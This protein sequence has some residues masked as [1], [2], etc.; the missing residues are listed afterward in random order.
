MTS[1]PNCGKPIDKPDNF[2]PN[3]GHKLSPQTGSVTSSPSSQVS[4]DQPPGPAS[5]PG[6]PAGETILSVIGGLDLKRSLFKSEP[7]NLVITGSRL[8]CVP[9][10]ALVEAASRQAEDMAKSEG[11]WLIGRWKAKAD[12]VQ[13]SDFSAHFLSRLPEGI[14]RE[15]PASI[16]IPLEDLTQ[17]AIRHRR[18]DL[19]GDEMTRTVENWSLVL[20]TRKTEYSLVSRTDP[21]PRFRDNAAVYSRIGDRLKIL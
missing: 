6:S 19:E 18:M 9:V 16:V 13:A 4:P 15:Y 10:A 17:I 20:K 1:C 14:L 11:K 8:L 21:A 2:C 7:V 12:V 5:S 3:C